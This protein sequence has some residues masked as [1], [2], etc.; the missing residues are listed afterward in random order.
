MEWTAVRIRLL[1]DVGLCQSQHDFARTPGFAKRTIGNAERGATH[2]GLA[3]RHALDKT[4]DVQRDRF[5]A[6]VTTDCGIATPVPLVSESGALG[7]Q[8]SAACGRSI[9]A[10][11]PPAH[12][13]RGL[14]SVVLG[15]PLPVPMGVSAPE[16]HSATSALVATVQAH[17]L[18]QLAEYDAA[19]Q[20]LPAVLTCLRHRVDTGSDERL[21]GRTTTRHAM[22]TA[23][24][25]TA[26]L[27]T[28]SGDVV[29]ASVAADRAERCG[30]VAPELPSGRNALSARFFAV[31]ARHH[32][33]A[34]W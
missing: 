17:R 32:R 15:T 34:V 6:A 9:V 3:L 31:T 12:A 16:T 19:A 8:V 14:R 26:K 4:S 2:P 25:A 28:K 21:A 1:R 27:A 29:L 24:L 18:Y 11:D 20:L 22:A 7:S 30:N 5:L 13:P 23:Y 10:P 33:R